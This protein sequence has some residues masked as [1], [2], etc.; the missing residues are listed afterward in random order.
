MSCTG[1]LLGAAVLPVL[2]GRGELQGGLL[3][4]TACSIISH[5]L[6]RAATHFF[7]SVNL[8]GAPDPTF[9]A[10]CQASHAGLTQE[11]VDA[12]FQECYVSREDA[13]AMVDTNT[14]ILCTHNE[15]VPPCL[16]ASGS[17]DAVLACVLVVIGS[18]G[19]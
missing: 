17:Y 18:L 3:F 7:L 9:Q 16:L 19:L 2:T 5:R 14:I 10:W 6:F 12:V 13:E 15:Q 1:S 11:A 4:C 8:R